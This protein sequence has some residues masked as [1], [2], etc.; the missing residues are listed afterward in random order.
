[1]TAR[2]PGAA[3]AVREAVTYVAG[4]TD[5]FAFSQAVAHLGW[6]PASLP[7]GLDVADPPVNV[8]SARPGTRRPWRDADLPL[9]AMGSST[10]TSSQVREATDIVGL[11]S[12]QLALKRVGRRFVG[13]CPFHTEKTPIFSVNPELGLYYCFGCQKSGDAITFVREVERLDFVEAVERLAGAC[14][15][16]A[17]L[18]RRR[19]SRR[20]ASARSGCTR[21]SARRSTSTTGVLL[22]QPTTAASRVATCAAAAST[23][24]RRGGSQLGW[25]PDDFDALSRHLQQARSS[26]ATTSSTPGSRS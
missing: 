22:E 15:H 21:R 25:S 9:G 17:A 4:M 18:R 10:T 5:R 13:L 20:T 11:I 2:V 24:T 14:R 6:D 12:E 1:M 3:Q 16:H 8:G 26:R 23:A 19:R 7:A